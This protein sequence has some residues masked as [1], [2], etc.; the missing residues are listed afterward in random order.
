MP[1][2]CIGMFDAFAGPVE[3]KTRDFGIPFHCVPSDF[4]FARYLVERG[5]DDGVDWAVA[6]NWELDH[7][8]MVPLSKLDPDGRYP[9]VPIFIN[10]AAPPLPSPRRCYAVGRWLADVIQHWDAG[11]RVAIIATGGLSH[12]V[13]SVQQG[14]IDTDFDRR[15]LDD[16]CAGRGAALS[17]LSDREIAATGTASGEIRSWIMLAGAFAGRTAEQVMYEPISGFD[18]GCAQCLIT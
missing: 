7:G 11:K 8:F 15:F 4:A 18:T 16:F 6:E 12:S 2:F 14:F 1:A 17:A 5:L 9:M 10:C 3:A 13:G